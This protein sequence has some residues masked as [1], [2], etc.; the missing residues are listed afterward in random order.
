M[1]LFALK[2]TSP[3]SLHLYFSLWLFVFHFSPVNCLRSQFPK[4]F[5]DFPSASPSLSLTLLPLS[6]SISLSLSL[7][8]FRI[9]IHYLTYLVQRLLLHNEMTSRTNRFQPL[10]HSRSLYRT[11]WH[12][13]NTASLPSC[14]RE[15]GNN[16][17]E[18]FRAYYRR[19]IKTEVDDLLERP[20][21]TRRRFSDSGIVAA[22]ITASR[23]A[24]SHIT[25]KRVQKQTL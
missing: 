20:F 21:V 4:G 8:H 12:R 2:K 18:Q 9:Y 6:I 15:P 14:E 11:A 23:A 24:A 19:Q 13:S 17:A 10:M 22:Y 7:S 1:R 25:G 3:F 5:K 16:F